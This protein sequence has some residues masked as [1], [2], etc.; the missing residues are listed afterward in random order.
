MENKTEMK[1]EQIVSW[2]EV[3]KESGYIKFEEGV[4]KTL[5]ITNTR[6]CKVEGTDFNDKTKII[7][8]D[9]L[10]ADCMN[11]D[12]AK[13]EKYIGSTSKTFI[14]ALGKHLF[15]IGDGNDIRTAIV[16]FSVKRIGKGQSTNY[17]IEN[18]EQLSSFDL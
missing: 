15:P 13:C 18:F 2:D 10:K 7:M 12:G 5:V 4:R 8:Q 17:D 11:E 3:M 6:V 1:E 14:R 9:K 16:K